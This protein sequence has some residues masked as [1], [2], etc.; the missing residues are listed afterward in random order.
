[1]KKDTKNASFSINGNRSGLKFVLEFALFGFRFYVYLLPS[2][3]PF[4][5]DCYLIRIL[6]Y[7][8]PNR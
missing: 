3:P 6:F 8:G 1:M 5:G 4:F 7:I 2:C